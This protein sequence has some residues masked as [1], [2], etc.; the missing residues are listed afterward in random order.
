MDFATPDELTPLLERIA[1][2]V[3]ERVI[4]LERPLAERGFYAIEPELTVLRDRVKAAGL[5]APQL[6]ADLGGMGLSLVAHAQVSEALGQSPLGHYVFGCAAPDAGNIE[7]LALH[8]SAAQRERYL[9]PLARGELR[10]CFAMTEPENPGSNPVRLSTTARREGDGFVL[11]GHKWFTT[12]ADGAAF[13]LVMAVTEPDAPP[14]ERASLFLVPAETPGFERLRNL[15]IL[16]HRGEGW[17]SHSEL[18]LRGCHVPA[19]A[20]LGRA[21]QGFSLGQERLGPGRIHHCMRWIGVCER[22]FSLMCERALDRELE[23]GEP[24]AAQGVVQ[25]WIAESRADIDAARL[26]VLRAAWTIDREGFQAAR[27]DVSLIKFHVAGVLWRLLD[28]ALQLHGALGLTDDTVLGLFFAHERGARIYDGPDEVHKVTAAR[29][30]LRRVEKRR[31]A[32]TTVEGEPRPPRPGEALDLGAL[33]AWL[34]AALGLKGELSV[35]QFPSGHSNLTY[36]VTVG[37]RE[38]VLRRPPFGTTVK[39]AHDMAREHRV[40]SCLS[41]AWPL[42]PK[43]LGLCEDERILGSTFYAMER[44][45]GLV[46]RRDLPAGLTLEPARAKALGE[47]FVRALAELHRLDYGAIGLADLGQPEGYVGRQLGGWTKRYGQ[48]KTDEVPA[49]E[50]VARWLSANEPPAGPPAL[51]HNDY[52]LDNLVLDPADPTCVRGVLDWEMSTLGDPFMD[53]GTALGYWVEASD[54]EPLQRLRFGPT[55]LPGMPTRAELFGRYAELVGRAPGDPVF[56]YAFGLF[57]TAVVAQQIYQRFVKGLTKDPRFAQMI[58]AVRV[59]AEQA[60]VAIARGR[61]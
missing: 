6:P 50:A 48:A 3:R 25:G 35:Q 41:R 53:L 10:S 32:A 21:G 61:L 57:K 30:I 22:A 58:D 29:R 27:T 28:R 23:P 37:G 9:L 7:L 43:P 49:V 20:L 59:L 38:L 42:A 52:K 13:A 17:F 15:P 16:G 46:L 1:T 11:D 8:A 51:L 31:A 56:Y 19:E 12:A 54:P 55:H 24:L 40:L 36:L 18:A 39:S 47:S 60:E 4:P 34:E 5:W 44:V 26:L 45:A 2:F 14:H 33:G